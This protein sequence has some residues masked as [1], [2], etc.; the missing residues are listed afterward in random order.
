MT[1]KI[2]FLFKRVFRNHGIE[3]F[4]YETVPD[5]AT[6]IHEK[7]PNA[8]LLDILLPG[9]SGIEILKRSEQL[10]PISLSS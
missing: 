2:S 1:R 5:M 7:K 3:V 4:T 10:P 6:E 8:I 9:I